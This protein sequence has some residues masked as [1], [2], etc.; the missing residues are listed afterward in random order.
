MERPLY[1]FGYYIAVVLTLTAVAIICFSVGG[2]VAICIK[3][4]K[5]HPYRRTWNATCGT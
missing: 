5:Y 2:V 1:L 4:F 3:F